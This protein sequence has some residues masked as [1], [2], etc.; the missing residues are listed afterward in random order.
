M[1]DKKLKFSERYDF[2]LESSSDTNKCESH[3]HIPRLIIRLTT[4]SGS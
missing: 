1:E 3:D 2:I 4:N